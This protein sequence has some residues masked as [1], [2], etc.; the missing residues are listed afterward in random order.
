[1]INRRVFL[2]LGMAG[3]RSTVRGQ[4]PV[5]WRDC[6]RQK[7]EWYAGA[8]AVRIADNVILYQRESGGW[9]KNID[10]AAILGPEERVRIARDRNRIDSTIDNGATIGQLKFLARVFGAAGGPRFRDSFIAGLDYLFA[11]QYPNGGWPQ[12]F[13]KLTG[14][15]R[16]ITFNDNAMIGVMELLREIERRKKDY[17]FVDDKRRGQAGRAIEKG[18][19]CILK[20]Q[21]RVAG[22]LT[23]WCAQHDEVTLA[24]AAARAYEKVS[25]S[26]HESVGIVRFL[27]GIEDPAPEIAASIEAAVAWFDRVKITGQRLAGPRNGSSGEGCQRLV[28]AGEGASPLWARFYEI[29]TD[30]PIFSGRDGLIKYSLEE[31][32]CERRNGYNWYVDTP[33]RLLD[34]E[35]PA[36]K[37]RRLGKR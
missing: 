13:P 15:Y 7:P 4:F 16:H 27:M 33:A 21:V 2:I 10:M 32:E 23:A 25:L 30:R 22:R 9:P 18:I 3:V 24:P 37:K 11:A 1:M 36:W 8:E 34:R 12:Y 31:I 26:G 5:R 14:Y 29:G 20:C 6:L 17:P 28:A 35:Y 19:D